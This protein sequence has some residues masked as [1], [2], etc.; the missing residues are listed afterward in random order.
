MSPPFLSCSFD[1]VKVFD[2]GF[3]LESAGL[4]PD[5][6]RFVVGASDFPVRVYDFETL[7]ELGAT[8]LCFFLCVC[9]LFPYPRCPLARRVQP[10]ASRP[11]P[12]HALRPGLQ[13]V[14]LQFRRWHH[15]HLDRHG[16]PGGR[17]CLAG[18]RT[19]FFVL[20][21]DA[22]ALTSGHK[23]GQGRQDLRFRLAKKISHK[24]TERQTH[25]YTH[26]LTT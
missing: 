23:G 15:S 17:T 13:G 25:I 9:V 18:S 24:H 26:W 7:E 10:G 11:R 8:P 5:K 20:I 12:L 1:P 21:K 4:S 2:A 14:R 22:H 6:K 16:R 19:L 3:D